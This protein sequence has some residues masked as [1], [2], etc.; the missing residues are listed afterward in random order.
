MMLRHALPGSALVATITT[1]AACSGGD[2]RARGATLEFDTVGD[3]IIARA[4]GPALW[5]DDVAL[6][7]EVRIGDLE[8]ADEYTFGDVASI[9]VDGEGAIY[10]LDRQALTVRKYSPAG[11]HLQNIGRSGG[12]PGELKQPHSLDFTPDGRLVVRDFGNARINFY[13]AAG[14][15]TGTLIIPSG[16]FTSTPM[17]ID[18]LGRIYTTVVSD[19]VE[20]QM[21][22]VGF[23]RFDEQGSV[24]DTIR[25]P[26][27]DF[28]TE[29]LLARSPDGN[30]MSA[31]SVPFSPNVQWTLDRGG[32]VVWGMS[33]V[34]AIHTIRDGRPYRITRAVEPVPVSSAEKSAEEERV[35]RNMKQVQP[36]WS[37]QGS[38]IPDVKPHF[39]GIT[40]A[41]DDRIW[42][43]V[44]Q[45]GVLEP[46]DT[47]APREPGELPPVDRYVEPLVYDL[48]ER[49][50]N[51]LARIE[52]PEKFRPMFMRGDYVWGVQRDEYDV[53]YVVRL[54]I[55]H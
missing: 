24:R 5:G 2:V 21:F 37:W 33:D 46:A 19:R 29:P 41:H 38:G 28:T 34:Y 1:L 26:R 55:V 48:F 8:G 45:P 47:T 14:E 7:E 52:L 6:R 22:K 13:D 16:F 40:V 36:N 31:T 54:R 17:Q 51:W 43:Q 25:N 50:G 15:S 53:N 49:D 20:G 44:S 3:T 4:E 35:K 9:T 30:S 32:N 27:P 12:G 10:V 11:Q 39:R 42:V 23:Q 18:T